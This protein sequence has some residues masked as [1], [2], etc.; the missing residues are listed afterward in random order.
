MTVIS[1]S[2]IWTIS[3]HPIYFIA[4]YMESVCSGHSD[5]PFRFLFKTQGFIRINSFIAWSA[6]N[7]QLPAASLI[8][9]CLG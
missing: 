8:Y 2:I 3:V 9:N 6:V 5:V 1:A 4:T 7:K